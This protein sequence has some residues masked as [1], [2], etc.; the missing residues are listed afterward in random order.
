MVF[1]VWRD[2]EPLVPAGFQTHEPSVTA[3]IAL[4]AIVLAPLLAFDRTGV[5]LGWGKGYYDRY[6]A[7]RAAAG[8]A[9]WVVGIG[10][11]CQQHDAV[12]VEP[13]DRRL[14]AV[15]TERGWFVC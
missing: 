14:D 15:V 1:R 8:A 2:T 13:H 9:P 6:L 10:F 12:P 11:A 7:A 3:P 4:P 5:R